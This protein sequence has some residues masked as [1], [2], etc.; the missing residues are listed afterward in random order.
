MTA[1][2]N[3]EVF[4]MRKTWQPKREQR[5]PVGSGSRKRLLLMFAGIAL[6]FAC[7]AGCSS[8]G[9]AGDSF[10]SSARIW[11]QPLPSASAWPGGQEVG[12]SVDFLSLFQANA[13]WPRA[14]A[15]T[16]AFGL[17]AG[18]ITAATDAELQGVVS[19]LN[20][21]NIGIEIEAPALQALA[22]CG[23]GVEGY[24]PYGQTV[25]DFTL[26]YLQRLQALNAQVLFIKVDEP[27]FFGTV[28]NNPQSCHFS[29]TQVATEVGQYV[30]LVKTIYPNAAVGDVEPII[31]SAYT[32]NVVTAIVQWHQTYQTVTGAPFPFFF[33]DIDFS[34]P[35]WPSLV[36]QLEGAIRQSGLQFGIIYIGDMQDTTDAEWTSK[37]IAR[38]E[39]YQ[40]ENGGQPDYVFFQSWEPHPQYC[41]PET[42]PITFTGVIDAYIDATT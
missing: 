11:F 18:W 19:F 6:A 36:K 9:R 25:Q 37:A 23:S 20:A 38:F 7:G 39:I 17:Y 12:G 33:A 1:I 3:Q 2:S 24:V 40:G 32:P 35:E 30:Q 13:P 34:N 5:N 16:Q 27:Y 14:M 22:T 15:K 28:V 21:H 26:A 41:L 8:G 42:S 10:Q 4:K 31:A 29:V